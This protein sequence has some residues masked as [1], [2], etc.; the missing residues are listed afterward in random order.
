MQIA[1][2]STPDEEKTCP[3]T[4]TLDT[5]KAHR[6]F[7]A[8]AFNACWKLIEQPNRT[9]DDAESMLRLAEVSMWHW[10]Q[11]ESHTDENLSIA[12]W[13]LARVYAIAGDGSRAVDYAKQCVAVSE[14]EPLGPFCIG[15]AYEALARAQQVVDPNEGWQPALDRAYVAADE[16]T[17]ESSR[18]QL[19][20]DLKTI[21][22]RS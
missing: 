13:Q 14:K 15:Y 9:A 20:T 3:M 16:I 7:A 21:A 12:Y 11:I 8:D 18:E 5:Q 6:H 1:Q 2:Q 19:L 4:D 10:Q 22:P 17:D